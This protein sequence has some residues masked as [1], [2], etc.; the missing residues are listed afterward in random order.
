MPAIFTQ[1]NKDELYRRMIDAGWRV[2]VE[3][4]I[5]AVRVEHIARAAGIAKGTFYHFFESKGAFLFAMLM[6]NRQHGVDELEARR[7]AAARPLTRD[8]LRAW[9]MFLWRSERNIFRIATADEY[10]YLVRSIPAGRS[11]APAVDG[12]LV[13]WI[14]SDVIEA[15]PD[16]NV[17]AVENLQKTLALALLNRRLLKEDAIEQ[18]VDA[19]VEASLDEL[20]R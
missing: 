10:A 15:R 18:V 8:E 12:R 5:R 6:E 13:R 3:E 11:L 9:F 4:G 14:V 17:H 1:E 16:V 19:L 20:F 2:V 7:I